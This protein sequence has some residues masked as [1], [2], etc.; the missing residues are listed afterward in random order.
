MRVMVCDCVLKLSYF[1]AIFLFGNYTIWKNVVGAECVFPFHYNGVD[2]M[3][4]TTVDHH[5]AWCGTHYATGGWQECNDLNE[6]DVRHPSTTYN[7]CKCPDKTVPGLEGNQLVCESLNAGD[8]KGQDVSVCQMDKINRE[9]QSLDEDL[10]LQPYVVLSLLVALADALGAVSEVNGDPENLTVHGDAMLSSVERLVSALVEPILTERAIDLT[11][12]KTELK[13]FSIGKDTTVNGNLHLINTNTDMDIDLLG[14]QKA[15]NGAAHVA[16]TTYKDMERY[17]QPELFH[18][19]NDTIKIMMS[20][21]F[22]ASLPKTANKAL[23]QPVNFTLHHLKSLD[24][25]GVLSCVYW[26]ASAWVVDGCD[27]TQTNATH[28]VCT[29][30]HLSTFCL[31]MQVKQLP[32]TDQMME[33]L[34]RISVSIGLV[35]LALAVMAFS[36]CRW[37][38][39]VNI[40]ARL[41][42][43]ISLFLAHLL[44]LLVQEFIH[45]IRPHKILCMIISGTLHFL[46]LSSFVWMSVEAVLLLLAVLSLKLVRRN[47]GFHWGYLCLIGYGAPFALVAVS[48]GLKHDGYGS[49][50]C[51]LR[52]ENGFIWSFLGPVCV[53]LGTNILLLIITVIILHKTLSY[54]KNIHSQ[55]KDIRVVVLKT[56]VQFF[57]IGGPWVLGF[58][59]HGNT[60]LELLFHVLNSQQGSFIFLIHCVLNAEVRQQFTT[61]CRG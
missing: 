16:L 34:N 26:N 13:T 23:T 47:V 7:Y 56:V 22:S 11:G 30:E 27:V 49:D 51:W 2:Y 50:R 17:L 6:T 19:E 61:I 53:I 57:I 52:H 35:F 29:C 37:K 9:L 24:P 20:S 59:H 60:V 38:A 55:I 3:E 45:L 8:C 44:F 1:L 48:A 41:N 33:L 46:F 54:M 10:I 25:E 42:L 28:T 39:Q 40:T 58:F 21:V 15:N 4:C 12:K 5:T 43:C 31:I 18:S 14:I 32:E 36:F